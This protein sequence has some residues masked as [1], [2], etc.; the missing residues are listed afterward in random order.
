M[1]EVRALVF[2]VFGTVVDWRGGVA[3]EAHAFLLRSGAAAPDGERFADR[4]RE[5]YNPAMAA[6]RTGAR[7]FAT[8]D[9]LNNETLRAVVREFGLDPDAINAGTLE[10]LN[11][12][13][14]R[15]D[16]WP[17]SVPGLRRLKR[18]FTLGTL[19]NGNIAIMVD[20]AKRAELPWDVILGAELA[21]TYKPDPAVYR[22]AAASLG[23][24]P[25]EL[26]LVAAHNADLAAAKRCGLRTAFVPRP[27]EHGPN[28]T[29]DL[30]PD[31]EWDV[32][33]SDLEDL[34]E[35]LGA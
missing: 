22:G 27:R 2:D 28:Q 6:V 9:V 31:G 13:W 19:S 15:L 3:R 20:M 10:E 29:V 34:A 11:R 32:V 26:C 16:P 18:R 4:W 7:P 5:H 25:P 21:R 12:V 30:E 23:L 35:R 8:L 24:E 33:A 17:D 14:H 1:R